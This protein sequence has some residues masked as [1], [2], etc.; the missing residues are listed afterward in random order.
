MLLHIKTTEP[1]AKP[2]LVCSVQSFLMGK[3]QEA[4]ILWQEV[5]PSLLH[6]AVPVNLKHLTTVLFDT[7][8]RH[9]ECSKVRS[10]ALML[11]S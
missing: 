6:V 9:E 5:K 11:V 10:Q 2:T 3:K 7:V 8:E 1:G 4:L